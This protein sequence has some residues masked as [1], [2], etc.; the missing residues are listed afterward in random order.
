[1]ANL[2]E[3]SA[4]VDGIYQLETSDPVQGGPDG[5]DNVQAKQLGSRTRY[6]K[7]RVDATDKRVDAMGQTV[8]GL[9]TDKLPIAGGAMKGALLGKPGEITALNK[10]NAGFVFDEDTDTGMFSPRDGYVQIG[11]NG[12]SHFEIRD[13]NTFVGPE[14]VA[15]LLVLVTG[16]AERARITSDGRMLVGTQG[17]DDGVSRLQV[18][19]TVR[20]DGV[21]SDTPD[22]GGAHFRAR[23]GGYGAYLRN[24]GSSVYLLSTKKGDPSGQPN[25]YRPFAWNLGTGYVTID[26]GGHG[27]AIGGNATIVG[28]V[29]IGHGLDEGHARI[30]PLDG[31]FYS[32]KTSVGWWSPTVGS[33]QYVAQDRTFRVDGYLVWHSGNMTPLDANKG[34]VIGGNVTFAAGQR[35]FLD[36]GSAAFPSLAFVNDGVPDTGFYHARDGV[37]GVTCNGEVTVT[38]AQE[39]T[40]FQKPAAG[41]SPA[42]DDSSLRFATT[43][44]VTAAIGTASIGQ[45]VMEA[46]TSPRAGYVKCDGSQYKRAD[47]PA[48]WAYAQASGALV[49]E[50]EYTD[51]RWGGFST[52]DGQTYFRVPDLRGEFLRCWSDGRGDVDP[53]RAIG[54]FQG[55]QNQAHAHGAS[56]DP[57]GAHVHDAWTGGAGWHSHHGVT[58]GGGMHNHA[59]GVFSRLLRPPYLGSLTGSDTD[60]SGNEQAV[61]GGDSADIAWAGEHQHEF[62]T[63][64]AG[65]HVHAVGIGNAGGHAHAIHVQADGGAEARPRNVALLAMIRAY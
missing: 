58:G 25:D 10:L 27:T 56:S 36:E 65:D 5:V 29:R 2:K 24:D 42:P 19:G 46:R 40:Y 47:Y 26:A 6:L 15:G 28:D 17:G 54:S 63:D 61:G 7:D 23:Y 34:G 57:D 55:G 48:L 43:E 64:G 51:G 60:G 53:G 32:N 16:A 11:G 59:N 35:L 3:D 9:G 52:A 33:F 50:A 8:A 20:A 22:A 45:I 30:G 44:W 12:V 38:F 37:F 18:A 62:W 14:A 49:S 41:P 31:Y 1:M 39:A 21:V 13:G 4:W